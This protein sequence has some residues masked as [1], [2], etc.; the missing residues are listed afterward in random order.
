VNAPPVEAAL[1]DVAKEELEHAE[2]LTERILQLGG[3]PIA[4]PKQFLEKTNCGYEVPTESVVK[5]LKDAIKGEGCAIGVYSK[6]AKMTKDTD[7][8]T[9]QLILHI[10]SEEEEHEER[11]ENLLD[12]MSCCQG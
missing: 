10:M 11:F 1:K 7:P 5:A 4:D 6:I 8:I 9:H 3:K 12:F 2:E